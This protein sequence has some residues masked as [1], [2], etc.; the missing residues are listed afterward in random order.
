MTEAQ[1]GFPGA[2][3][4]DDI[5]LGYKDVA[6]IFGLAVYYSLGVTKSRT[7]KV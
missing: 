5:V 4:K 3:G 7:T 2:A 6:R 1:K